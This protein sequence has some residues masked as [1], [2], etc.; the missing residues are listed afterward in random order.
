[1]DIAEA[2]LLYILMYSSRLASG[3]IGPSLGLVF[4]ISPIRTGDDPFLARASKKLNSQWVRLKLLTSFTE[5]QRRLLSVIIFF[6]KTV[7]DK[8]LLAKAKK[9][10]NPSCQWLRQL[11]WKNLKQGL[12]LKT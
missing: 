6:K 4:L 3:R 8:Y 5:G 11:K 1:M 10:K 12:S 9:I 7:H 2:F